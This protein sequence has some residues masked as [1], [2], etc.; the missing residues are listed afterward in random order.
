MSFSVDLFALVCL[1]RNAAAFMADSE[2]VSR[3]IRALLAETALIG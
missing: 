1:V 3:K 2:A